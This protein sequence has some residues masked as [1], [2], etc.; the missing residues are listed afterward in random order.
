MKKLLL[1]LILSFFSAQGLAASCPDGS[2]PV[3]SISADG[4]YFVYKCSNNSDNVSNSNNSA[5]A[6]SKSSTPSTNS[7]SIWKDNGV[8]DNVAK[9]LSRVGVNSTINYMGETYYDT[10]NSS[11]IN[12]NI[13]KVKQVFNDGFSHFTYVIS[14]TNKFYL[15]RCVKIRG[16]NEEKDQWNIIKSDFSASCLD[17]DS[18][19]SMSKSVKKQILEVLL[20]IPDAVFVI[21]LKSGFEFKHYLPNGMNQNIWLTEFEQKKSVRDG[22]NEQWRLIAE[23]LKDIPEDNL[24]F[25]LL[26]EPEFENFKGGNA[27]ETWE[28]WTTN[29]V[30]VIRDI[31]PDRTII[32]EGIYKSL[33]ARHNGPANVIRPIPRK[34]IVYGFH[35]YPHVEWATQDYYQSEGGR[36]KGVPMPSL[37][38]P[39]N[40]FRQL[41][42]Y[43]NSYKVPVA[44]TEI[45]VVNPCEGYGP[46]QED[47]AK[48]AET[49]Y[50]ALV[51]NGIGMTFWG[52]ESLMSPYQRIKG[53]CYDL[54]DKELIPDDVLFKAL[55]LTPKLT[56]ATSD[57]E[58]FTK[59]VGEFNMKKLSEN[60]NPNISAFSPITDK[61]DINQD[62]HDDFI[63]GNTTLNTDQRNPPNEFSKPVILFWDNNIKEYVVDDNVQKSLPFLYF[64]RRIHGS[65]N[66]KTGLT[67]LFI[68]DTGL[69]L[70]NYNMSKGLANLPPNCGAQNHLI[71]YDPSSKKVT[72]IQL[73]KLWDYSHALAAADMNG[74]QITDYVVLNSP[75]I[76]YPQKCSFNGVAYTNGSY[77]LYSNK[78]GGFDKVNIQL[79]YKGYS[80][81]PT[82]TSGIAI[83]D[84]NND[85]F[86][87]LGSEDPGDS[88][89]AFKQ[90]SKTSFTETSRVNAPA[91]MSTNGKSGA[92]SEVLYADVDSD[93]TKEV[94]ASVNSEKWTGRYIQLLDFKNGE[95][96]DR[97]KDVVQSNPASK[98]GN[99]WCLHLFFN[100]KTAWNEPILTCTNNSLSHKSR[101]Y[102]Y[103]WTENK[104]QLAKIKSTN[105]EAWEKEILEKWIREIYPMTIDQ[106]NVFVGHELTGERKV[107]GHSFFDVK[108]FNLIEPPE[109]PKKKLAPSN[110]FDGN[111]KFKLTLTDPDGH[112]WSPG[113]G[114][115]EIKNGILSVS[116]KSRTL[117][118]VDSSTDKFDTFEGQI[119]KNGDFMATFEF[120]ACGPGDCEEEIIVLEGNINNNSKLSG[121]FLDKVV[122]F[123]LT[124]EID[125]KSIETSK[126][127][128]GMH[129]F[130]LFAHGNMGKTHMGSGIFK[131]EDGVV[132]IAAENRTRVNTYTG[133]MD[134]ASPNDKWYN[135]FNGRVNKLGEIYADFLYNPC[136]SGQCGGDKTF[137]VNGS[138]DKH[139]L[140]GEFI[141][142]TGPD[143]TKI[144][145]EFKGYDEALDLSLVEASDEFDLSAIKASDEFDGKYAFKLISNPPNITKHQIGSGYFEIKSGFITVATQDRVL[146]ASSNKFVTNK[147]YNKFEGRIDAN[148]EIQ[149]NFFF[150]PC[151]NGSKCYV[152][153]EGE[154]NIA[155]N[156][157]KNITIS[158]NIKTHKLTGE[159]TKGSGPDVV[160]II[161]EIEAN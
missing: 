14:N 128:D 100:E 136:G 95:L 119:D 70:A 87:L 90:D 56:T 63:V 34:N 145:F 106:K 43:S 112:S 148:G 61:F 161:F 107:N 122:A 124:K 109:P 77:I 71:T 74:D 160:K 49:A 26:N 149:A 46:L 88:I 48:Y 133:M 146:I 134:K 82:I 27:R 117:K 28:K 94:V 118:D 47:N 126:T 102:F 53:R 147:Y 93:G 50:E 129:A 64:P 156:D 125:I 65:I 67:H 159:F 142:G 3:K 21:S 85:T 15:D 54:F 105:K 130:K 113:G 68:A 69:D 153:E 29:T 22:F 23:E 141:L 84:D 36:G 25:N 111:Y 72:E 143:V 101:G 10:I 19:S 17:K 18:I 35:Y 12:N 92:Y 144:I 6:T 52:L 31:S 123:E 9:Q 2:E 110:D 62:G 66:P 152:Q 89:Y 11:K 57:L 81:T 76:K 103:T 131:I 78:N 24:A 132:V 121:K 13:D 115:I 38:K 99:D 51:P 158:G 41:V 8:S 42:D 137:P 33:F 58:M 83:V 104:L 120:N 79:N 139:K 98:D 155:I 73:P 108:V 140:N 97:S 4:T 37:N 16:F 138:I 59:F 80:K 96:R 55:R 7:S 116:I 75:Y 60:S 30:D 20:E 39:K 32:I 157:D 44:V 135:S 91:I 127:F 86:L 114:L 150:N 5:T 1:L 154:Y 45:A 40:D 151:A